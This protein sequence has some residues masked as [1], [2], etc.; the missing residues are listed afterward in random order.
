MAPGNQDRP[1]IIRRTSK[2]GPLHTG[3]IGAPPPLTRQKAINIHT[4][5]CL[6]RDRV[7]PAD[8]NKIPPDSDDPAKH[9]QTVN[10]PRDS[11]QLGPS[12]RNRVGH[13]KTINRSGRLLF[14]PLTRTRIRL[15]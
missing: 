14:S 15:I 6:Q 13:S 7:P 11:G 2:E 1:I 8:H 12:P 9:G 10:Q 4:T 5:R 3:H